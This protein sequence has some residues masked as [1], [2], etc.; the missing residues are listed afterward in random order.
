MAYVIGKSRIGYPPVSHPDAGALPFFTAAGGG[1][2]NKAGSVLSAAMGSPWVGRVRK[3]RPYQWMSRY[4]YCLRQRHQRQLLCE[5]QQFGTQLALPASPWAMPL[6]ARA[7]T[8]SIAGHADHERSNQ[9]QRRPNRRLLHEGDRSGVHE[10]DG[11]P[12]QHIGAQEQIANVHVLKYRKR[13]VAPKYPRR[14]LYCHRLIRLR[15]RWW[16]PRLRGQYKTR[17]SAPTH[18]RVTPK[19]E[20]KKK[21]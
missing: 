3:C 7:H 1:N 15:R 18:S 11:S 9:P 19:V 6:G 13:V 12:E 4:G 10:P 20:E 16:K 14:R 21:P 2:L 8:T 17:E 5:R